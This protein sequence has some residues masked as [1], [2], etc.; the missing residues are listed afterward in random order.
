MV[1]LSK[2]QKRALRLFL[3]RRYIEPSNG[4]SKATAPR[5]TLNSLVKKGFAKQNY[6]TFE[7]TEVG[8]AWLAQRDIQTLI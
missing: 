7:I 3:D 1:K 4:F 5:A 2:V 6:L 8:R